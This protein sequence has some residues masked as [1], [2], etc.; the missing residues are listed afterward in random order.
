V[1]LF[2]GPPGVGKTE[3]ARVL[4][5][6][7]YGGPDGLIRFDMGD[8]TEAHATA[9]LTGSPPGYVAYEQGAPLVE[10]LRTQPYCLL[11]FDEIEHA[12]ENVLAVLLRLLSEGTLMDADGNV[13]DARNTIVIMTSNVLDAAWESSRVG[14][15]QQPPGATVQPTQTA[16]R[17]SL[18]RHFS[19]KFI[20]RLDAIICFSLLTLGDLQVIA[21]QRVR[22][23]VSRV[24]ARHGVPVSV[25]PEVLPWLAKKA[26]SESAGAR[27]I[28]RT[29]D[30]HVGSV[31]VAAL[32][33]VGSVE[34]SCF[35]LVVRPD[36]SGTEC[37]PREGQ[38]QPSE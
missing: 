34:T 18:E 36:Q 12:H 23:V 27:A 8:F 29:V 20:D 13:A 24:M 31:L 2:V 6:E 3:L 30:E 10:R 1:F 22:E 19:R 21:G 28:Q 25:S 14:F 38:A 4:A 15:T 26:A 7:V 32:S 5:E 9:R 17:A 11:L 35:Q 37:I 33:N 16:L